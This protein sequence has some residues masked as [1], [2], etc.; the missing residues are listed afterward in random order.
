MTAVFAFITGQE[1]EISSIDVLGVGISICVVV[2]MILLVFLQI[3]PIELTKIREATR[4]C[5]TAELWSKGEK[6][7]IVV[8]FYPNKDAICISFGVLS[9]ADKEYAFRL[10][11]ALRALKHN[12]P[13]RK[14]KYR[15]LVD[16]RN[17]R[18]IETNSDQMNVIFADWGVDG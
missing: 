1:S 9:P 3:H 5:W 13:E 18:S 12:D 8:H 16:I 10:I 15:V 11:D 7:K 14:V 4:D 17:A 6:Y 2:W